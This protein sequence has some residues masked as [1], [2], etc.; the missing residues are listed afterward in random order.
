[1]S[2]KRVIKENGK[3]IMEGLTAAEMEE[4]KQAALRVRMDRVANGRPKT[5]GKRVFK[6]YVG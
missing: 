5:K 2:E 4:I 3:D 1:M 6:R